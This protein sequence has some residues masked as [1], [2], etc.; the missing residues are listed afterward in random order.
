MTNPLEQTA[1][2]ALDLTDLAS[3]SKTWG[4]LAMLRRGLRGAPRDLVSQTM[5]AL[6]VAHRQAAHPLTQGM[7]Q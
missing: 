7:E 6:L 4:D 3:V 5:S 2:E 1:D